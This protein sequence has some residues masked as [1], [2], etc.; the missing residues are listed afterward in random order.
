MR[1]L[2]QRERRLWHLSRRLS[3]E[4]PRRCTPPRRK[5]A[6]AQGT[7]YLTTN[8]HVNRMKRDRLKVIGLAVPTIA[9]VV[10]YILF[11]LYPHWF[12]R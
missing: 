1:A 10:F 4:S 9:L 11:T 2:F 6:A 12:P 3:L 8:M 7:F 5:N